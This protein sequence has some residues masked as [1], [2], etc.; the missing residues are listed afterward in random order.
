M[1][2]F[3]ALHVRKQKKDLVFIFPLSSL[4]H[5][6]SLLEVAL[7]KFPPK[8]QQSSVNLGLEAYPPFPP[9]RPRMP[10]KPSETP[11][12]PYRIPPTQT[13]LRGVFTGRAF[14]GG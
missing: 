8:V 1:R 9:E 4:S 7:C 10:R 6:A 14:S 13:G 11:R 5:K 12:K 3:D 2:V